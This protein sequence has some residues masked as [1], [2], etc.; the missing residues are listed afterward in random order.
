MFSGLDND[1]LILYADPPWDHYGDPYK[2]GAAGKEY[3][4][5]KYEELCA[6]PF[7]SI[8]AKKSVLFCWFLL[9][10][11]DFCF[12]IASHWGLHYRGTTKLWIK[13][14]KKGKI[15]HGQGPRPTFTHNNAEI[16]T[17]WTTNKRGRTH[18]ILI[19]NAPQI[20]K[21]QRT[22]KHSEKPDVFRD[23]IVE[24]LGDLKRIEIF[25]TKHTDGWDV[26]GYGV[27]KIKGPIIFVDQ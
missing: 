18:P 26:Y 2:D 15:I 17:A 4:L 19:E 1:Y 12:D 11:L 20:V 8:M 7:K 5:M 13:I 24:L 23:S 10:R 27:N 6:I 21:A 25:A 22:R 9:P 16:L 3:T 14:N